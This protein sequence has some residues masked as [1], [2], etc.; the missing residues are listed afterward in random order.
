MLLNDFFKRFLF[1]ARI[2]AEVV[3][4]K[5]YS[6]RIVTAKYIKAGDKRKP[7]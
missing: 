2:L 7:V 3:K 4:V 6:T 1:V 5:R